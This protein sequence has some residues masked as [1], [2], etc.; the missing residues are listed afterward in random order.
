MI[1]GSITYERMTRML[2]LLTHY[3]EFPKLGWKFPLN[4]VL[5]QFTLFGH[6]FT[7]KWYGVCI[8]VG[9]LLAVV[10]AMHRAKELDIDPDR[11][12]DVALVCTI[13]GFVCARLYYVFFCGDTAD[14][15]A[16][17]ETIFQIWKGGLG[18]Y[19]GIIGAFVSGILMCR[20]KKIHVLAMFDLASLGFLIGQ[21]VGRWGNFFNQEA[22]GG[23]TTLPWGMTGDM[24]QSGLGLKGSGYDTSLPV[25]PTFFYESVWCLLGFVLLHLLSKKAYKFKGEIFCGYLVW[26]GVGRFFIESLRTDSLM[27]GTIKTSQLVAVLAIIGGIVMF[28]ILRRRAQSLPMTLETTA[29]APTLD[30]APPA[31]EAAPEIAESETVAEE[32]AKPKDGAETETV[33]PEETEEKPDGEDH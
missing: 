7:I 24:I 20:L 23:N 29:D 12:I 18:I 17:P 26:Y 10:Y 19:G 16:H 31:E 13:V 4:D 33:D 22:F 25:H 32:A 28:C 5:A 30:I 9:F 21:C 11:M 2:N 15:L 3:I 8:A 6:E 14:Y 1:P 27:V